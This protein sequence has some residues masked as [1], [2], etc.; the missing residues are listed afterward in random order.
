MLNKFL[1][2]GHLSGFSQ[3]VG[4]PW[5]PK[6]GLALSRDDDKVDDDKVD[7]DISKHGCKTPDLSS[8]LGMCE[9]SKQLL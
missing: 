7:N 4:I 1:C 6:V 2:L 8:F 3:M 5:Q 9:A